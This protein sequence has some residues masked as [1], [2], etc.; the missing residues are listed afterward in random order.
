MG[1]LDRLFADTPRGRDDSTPDGTSVIW[2]TAL[3][4][5]A[6]GYVLVQIGEPI[7]DEEAIDAGGG[8]FVGVDI[9]DEDESATE[10]TIDED[11]T[12]DTAG[13]ADAGIE[14]EDE[15]TDIDETDGATSGEV[16]E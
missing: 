1:Y 5:S 10:G 7:E 14:D 9:G 16:I 3:A 11:A 15:T 6:G 4:D 2:A 8:E 12:A 13:D